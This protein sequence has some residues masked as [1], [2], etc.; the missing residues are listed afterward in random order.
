MPAAPQHRS[1]AHERLE[2]QK[3]EVVRGDNLA[4]VHEILRDIERLVRPD[5]QAAAAELTRILREPNFQGVTFQ[6]QRG[7][8][9]IARILHVGMV[10]QQGLLH[11]G[12]V[13]REVNGHKVGSDPRALQDSLRL[14]SGSVVL[15][16]L[17]SYQEPPPYR[18]V[19]PW[20]QP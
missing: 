1:W 6:V 11:V 8:L 20:K 14:A 9:V 13:I 15:K 17:P 18:Q 4:L 2:E 7:E 16:I 19:R 12:D 5:V 10:A 3:L